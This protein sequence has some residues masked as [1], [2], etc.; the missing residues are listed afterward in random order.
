M[1]I[2]VPTR[3]LLLS[4]L[5]CAPACAFLV[6]L[7]TT[8]G[9][10]VA[11]R[12]QQATCDFSTVALPRRLR[13]LVSSLSA[14]STSMQIKP[15][16]PEV[17]ELALDRAEQVVR[18]AGGCIDSL[19]F[20]R[21]W[22]AMFPESSR[23]MF[24]GTSVTSFNK[25]LLNYGQGRF[26]VEDTKKKEVKLFV[27]K[28]VE[29]EEGRKAYQQA[30]QQL[31]DL[32][33]SPLG[34]FFDIRGG[35]MK[36]GG[37]KSLPPNLA[38]YTKLEDLLDALE[39]NLVAFAGGINAVAG[40]DA[41]T[42][43]N[44]IKRLNYQARYEVQ[45]ARVASFIGV[46]ADIATKQMANLNPKSVALLLNALSDREGFETTFETAS[47]RVQALAKQE[48]EQGP[49]GGEAGFSPQAVAIIV[50]ASVKRQ[51]RDEGLFRALSRVVLGLRPE[52][53]DAQAVA[54][55]ANAFANADVRPRDHALFARLSETAEALAP[56]DWN[57]AALSITAQALVKAKEAS[58]ALLTLLAAHAV[59]LY[60]AEGAAA[61]SSPTSL[62]GLLEGLRKGGV[63]S[64]DAWRMAEEVTVQHLS[65]YRSRI[66]TMD[67]PKAKKGKGRRDEKVGRIG[68]WNPQEV[69]ANKFG[70]A[71]KPDTV[72]SLAL[73]LRWGAERG[74]EAEVVAEEGELRSPKGRGSKV[75]DELERAVLGVEFKPEHA[76]SLPDAVRGFGP[77]KSK[78]VHSHLAK[79]ILSLPAATLSS[80]RVASSLLLA[81]ADAK[82]KDGGLVTRLVT[83]LAGLNAFSFTPP[84]LLDTLSAIAALDMP[85]H[86]GPLL[87][88]LAAAATHLLAVDLDTAKPRPG[89]TAQELRHV[90]EKL[91][92][93]ETPAAALD[94][95]A[96]AVQK[97][98]RVLKIQPS[99]C[100]DIQAVGD[101]L[102]E[103][104]KS[105]EAQEWRDAASQN[106]LIT[107]MSNLG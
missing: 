36:A 43:L 59:T 104:G 46:F 96:A 32:A 56:Q 47:Q 68:K 67:Q 2:A 20:G 105:A 101:L 14:S 60:K 50:N 13:N 4:A 87:P 12:P 26:F 28:D 18:A 6:P 74:S 3:L 40:K 9:S 37:A 83:T 103:M 11:L 88:R 89:M 49:A 35:R 90:L 34:A 76:S 5:L 54:N 75:W 57:A 44:H 24:Q 70:K 29:G 107:K 19:S 48:A 91:Y 21:E 27:L 77:V 92:R 95:T 10:L 106:S 98:L 102:E 45:R 55:I 16:D 7:K 53:F 93:L 22:R 23:D 39:P 51:R 80:P 63:M 97:T 72:S 17:V 100:K 85:R 79:S 69:Q 86:T 61:W 73:S 58:P 71:L 52:D 94:V 30:E 33:N 42:A 99:D 81:M 64:H 82:W 84:L 65:L 38:S 31:K 8:A 25:L 1:A 78:A 41:A 62:S 15:P 66:K